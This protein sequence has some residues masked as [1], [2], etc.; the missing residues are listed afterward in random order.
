MSDSPSN[1]PSPD[2]NQPPMVL[3]VRLPRGEREPRRDAQP[4]GFG[5]AFLVLL[6]LAS[7]GV[8]F[9][10]C[11]GIY[12]FSGGS[13]SGSDDSLVLN[14]KHWSGAKSA[15]D[16]VAVI[17]VEG[18]ILDEAMGYTHKQIEKAATDTSVKAIVVR[19]NSPGGTV[20]GSDDIHK[21]L[22]ELR[23]GNSPRYGTGGT[24]K[25]MVAS[26]GALAASGGYYIAMPAK[27]IYAER[28]T[29]TGSI[30]V[31]A[32]FINVHKLAEDNGVKMEII[33]AGDVK[34]AGSMFRELKPQE[35]Q[36]WQDSVDNSYAQ[37]ISIVED[38][39]PALKGM[40][41]KDLERVDPQGKR[42]PDEVPARDKDG[43]IDLTAKAI[44]YKRK[45]A[46]GGIFTAHEAK[47]YQLVDDIGFLEDATKKA[48][49]MANLTDYEVI[50]YE[51]PISLLSLFGG[52][53][54]QTQPD[55]AK[56]ASAAGPRI[57]FLAPHAE[58][59]GM[60]AIMG[61]R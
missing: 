26:M 1:S 41:T 42:L 49:T 47:H 9:L 45:L 10:L 2:A 59:A 57:W 30:G 11:L 54:N 5:R 44:P 37:F 19:I 60:L 34:A 46:D 28:T 36:M 55:F 29:M 21:R 32:A 38:G 53:M 7:I 12:M 58:F 14:E 8:N 27:H 4:G 22:T 17:R 18:I 3:P 35:R 50:V 6:L 16:K 43:N 33:K 40:L 24:A 20:T 52:G 61:K 23:D 15:R 48:A 13:M 31:Y 56:F 25:P 51:R 39:R